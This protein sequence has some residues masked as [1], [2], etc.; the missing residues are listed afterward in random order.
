MISS[1]P[2]PLKKTIV[3]W[4]SHDPTMQ[5]QK[6][7]WLVSNRMPMQLARTANMGVI[8]VFGLD[9]V[10]FECYARPTFMIQT[11]NLNLMFVWLNFY[12][13][14]VTTLGLCS[15]WVQ[16]QH[17]LTRVRKTSLLAL[18]SCLVSVISISFE[19][20]TPLLLHNLGRIS[21]VLKKRSLLTLHPGDWAEHEPVRLHSSLS[22]SL[23]IIMLLLFMDGQRS[24]MYVWQALKVRV[25][26]DFNGNCSLTEHKNVFKLPGL[27][28]ETSKRR[29]VR[30]TVGR[31]EVDS[32][33]ITAMLG[34]HSQS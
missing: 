6:L 33:F 9:Q 5:E 14:L 11:N 29:Q 32:S 3:T 1:P 28:Q 25:Q 30:S 23:Q 26:N 17:H 2:P 34:A 13:S 16:A 12:F 20:D 4:S 22:R 24:C 10:V 27:Y 21:V 18:N 19:T 7:L 8:S 31:G 15:D